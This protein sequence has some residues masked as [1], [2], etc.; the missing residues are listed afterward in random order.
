MASLLSLG[1]SLVPA[2]HALLSALHFMGHWALA[3]SGFIAA[4]AAAVALWFNALPFC[5]VYNVNTERDGDAVHLICGIKNT[6]NGPAFRVT[7]W[8]LEY[9][10]ISG[11]AF[12]TEHYIA[13]LGP[14]EHYRGP[15]PVGDYDDRL[16][17]SA[18]IS[19]GGAEPKKEEGEN[20]MPFRML[21]RWEA[22][23]WTVG[24]SYVEEHIRP[25]TKRPRIKVVYPWE[26]AWRTLRG[27]NWKGRR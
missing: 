17:R 27:Y 24:E 13:P 19:L 22:M 25:K 3:L 26:R 12:D 18:S 5:D 14:G 1:H 16:F 2:W 7:L 11:G 21:L 4:V 20:E 9:G 8:L 15:I 6:G 23:F 10:G